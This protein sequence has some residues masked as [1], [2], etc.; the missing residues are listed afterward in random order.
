VT[1]PHLPDAPGAPLRV[2]RAAGCWVQDASGRRYLDLTGAAGVLGH[3]HRAVTDA[4][5]DQLDRVTSTGR[6]L[7]GDRMQGL[8]DALAGLAPGARPTVLGSGRAALQAAVQAARA[9]RPDGATWIVSESPSAASLDGARP[10]GHPS[11]LAPDAAIA[12]VVVEPHG[13][14]IPGA[15]AA[16]GRA[17]ARHDVALVL[18]ETRFGL[19]RSG[20]ATAAG[21]AALEG[22]RPD[23]IAVSDGLTGGIGELGALLAL[24][25]ELALPPP[26]GVGPV[27]AAAAQAAVTA[28]CSPDLLARGRAVASG[29]RAAI[30]PA[31]SGVGL[32]VEV[33][34]GGP[35][36]T[37]LQ[38]LRARGLLA[39]PASPD[40][41]ALI[42]PL[43]MTSSELQW[44]AAQLAESL[45]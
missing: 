28:L 31:A 30:G 10:E 41:I 5:R 19:G 45:R 11:A 16:L 25:P 3:R 9:R 12:A 35:P 37:A 24:R 17:C 36:G 38:A 29:L 1:D 27:Q 26:S 14:A 42:P 40:R 43:V 6:W 2:A 13:G 15:W 33:A 8:L 32:W 23:W 44:A 22:L 20:A 4:V 7:D 21:T 39:A 34:L 18:D